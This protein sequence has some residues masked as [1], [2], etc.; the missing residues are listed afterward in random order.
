VKE[1]WQREGGEEQKGEGREEE[2]GVP[3]GGCWSCVI[4]FS[5]GQVDRADK[6]L[7]DDECSKAKVFEPKKW[8][9]AKA[10]AAGSERSEGKSSLD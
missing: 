2:S 3:S 7:F 1:G 4:G 5:R 9:R 10:A 6:S 8:R